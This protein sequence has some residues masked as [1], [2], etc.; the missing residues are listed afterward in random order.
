M[1]VVGGCTGDSG[2][3][4]AVMEL[5]WWGKRRKRW[6]KKKNEEDKK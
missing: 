6:L 3:M 2:V 4:V 1:L 5:W